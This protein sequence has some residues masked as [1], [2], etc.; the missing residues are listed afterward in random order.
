MT[1][2]SRPFLDRPIARVCA[3]GVVVGVAGVLLAMHWDD[4]FAEPPADPAVAGNPALAA[5]LEKR[6]GDVAEM[7][8]TGT[9]T[10]AQA[11]QFRARAEDFCHARH[12]QSGGP[13]GGL[14]G[15]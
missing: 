15:Q 9:I 8:E 7:L 6:R 13:S 5:C 11:E 3:L 1:E 12:G 14:L 10:E 4:L 2:S